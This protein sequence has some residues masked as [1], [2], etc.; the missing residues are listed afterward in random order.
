MLIEREIIISNKLSS[1]ERYYDTE[2]LE[3]ILD[4]CKVNPLAGDALI[5]SIIFQLIYRP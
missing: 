1:N 2:A 5:L 4:D 3:K